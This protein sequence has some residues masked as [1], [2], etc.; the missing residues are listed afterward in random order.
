MPIYEYQCGS[1]GHRLEALQS[2]DDAPLSE[3]P[4][5]G[6][7]EL[8]RL[9]SAAGFQLKGSGWYKSDYAKK[10]EKTKPKAEEPATTGGQAAGATD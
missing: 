6:Q 5:C 2:L 3:C 4:V 1:C 9:I 10:P 7:S 8:T